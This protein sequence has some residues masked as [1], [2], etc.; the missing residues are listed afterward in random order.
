VTVAATGGPGRIGQAGL[1]N[2]LAV[3]GYTAFGISAASRDTVNLTFENLKA[4]GFAVGS[5]ASCP[6]G[7]TNSADFCLSTDVGAAAYQAARAAI[8]AIGGAGTIVHLTGD[9]DDPD[10]DRRIEG[11]KKAVTETN[12]RVTELPVVT[13]L[14]KDLRTAQQAVA[15]LLAAGGTNLQGIVTTA[16][17]PAVAAADEVAGRKLPVKVVAVDDDPTI[18]TG[19]RSGGIAAAV[20]QNPTGQ[21][22]VGGWLLALL[23]SK[24]CQLKTPGVVVDSGSF[25]VTKD[26]VDTYDTERQARTEQL[27]K[28]FTARLTCE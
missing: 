26:N 21:A 5:L 27:R 20:T 22:Y 17:H 4:K 2:S 11:V 9:A 24:Q 19:V 12:G 18:L 6:A 10:T 23:G 25:V 14:D 7:E 16:H 8:E 15:A 3:Q 28:E 1:I 13:G